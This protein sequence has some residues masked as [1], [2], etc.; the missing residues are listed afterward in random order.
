MY[1]FHFYKSIILLIVSYLDNS[2]AKYVIKPLKFLQCY[3]DGLQFVA[4]LLCATSSPILICYEIE[5]LTILQKYQDSLE[6]AKYVTS[7]NPECTECWFV[8]AD[9]YLHQKKYDKCLLVLNNIYFLREYTS[10]DMKKMILPSNGLTINEIPVQKVNNHLLPSFKMYDL[11]YC[12]KHYIDFYYGSSQFYL[13]EN[14]DV[15]QDTIIKI[16]TSS[17]FSF[18]KTQQ[19][20]YSL[21]LD[22]IKEINFDTFIDLKNKMFYNNSLKNKEDDKNMN[23]QIEDNM[24]YSAPSHMKISINPYLDIIVTNLIED[25]KLFS[26]VISQEDSYFQLLISKNDLAVAEIKFCFSFALISERLKYYHTAIK[27][28]K[29]A[30]SFCF[31]KFLYERLIKLYTKLKDFK[32][33]IV[34]L[35][36]LL[37]V[38]S[39]EQLSNVN[40]TPLWI[41]KIVLKILFEYQASEIIQWL[42]GSRKNVIDYIK[43]I[44]NKYKYWIE[45]GH[46]LHLIK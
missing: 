16:L 4:T 5:L 46:E 24:H 9:L 35:G 23:E 28:Y 13:C 37:K 7:I 40:K 10:E 45:V 19:R 38:L 43:N 33:A 27:F 18:D 22:M 25:L 44:I 20:I 34:N 15:L 2:F 42:D 30:L 12:P 1:Y 41:D 29:K 39:N 3:E 17:Y 14:S 31:S 8:L 32:T 21:L 6:L 36:E 11:L 26:V